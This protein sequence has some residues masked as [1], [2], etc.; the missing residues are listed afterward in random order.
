MKS[1]TGSRSLAALAWPTTAAGAVALV[2][3]ACASSQQGAR[4]GASSTVAS[5]RPATVVTRYNPCALSFPGMPVGRA[6]ANLYAGSLL[7]QFAVPAGARRLASAP[8]AGNGSLD[9]SLPPTGIPDQVSRAEFWQVPGNP[10]GVLAW[11]R[12]QVPRA[13]AY[14]GSG[15]GSRRGVTIEWQ[16]DYTLPPVPAQPSVSGQF[17]SRA[18]SLFAVEAGNGRTDIEVVVSVQW[19]PPRA[20]SEVVPQGV[21]AIT[22]AAVPDMNLRSTPP[23]AVTVTD[24][25]Q[26]RR[27]VGLVDALPL[28]PPGVFSCPFDAGA[29]VVLTF[30]AQGAG[31]AVL[32][33]AEQGLEGCEWT[34]L[35]IGSK[36]QPSLG[37]PDGGRP[38]AAEILRI[39]GLS[40]NLAKLVM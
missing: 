27:I 38:T 23:A 14:N 22:I 21:R 3:A 37:A 4:P 6:L 24:P 36:Q 9:Q 20:A 19:I 30:R 2:L 11:E 15:S 39:A 25:A 18:M 7:C 32:A 12:R 1:L 13:L 29:R 28:S 17:N 31:G 8:N 16:D 34:S 40:W 35:T 5:P 33:V 26:V 10:E